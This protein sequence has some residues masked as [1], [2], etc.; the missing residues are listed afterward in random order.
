MALCSIY[1]PNTTA[2]RRKRQNHPRPP[3]ESSSTQ[4]FPESSSQQ[5]EPE[6]YIDDDDLFEIER[7]INQDFLLDEAF[8]FDTDELDVEDDCKEEEEEDDDDD[9]EE[10]ED[11]EVGEGASSASG[12]ECH[13]ESSGS[14]SIGAKIRPRASV[15]A[16]TIN[17]KRGSKLLTNTE[18]VF[19]KPEDCPDASETTIV[20]IDP[21]EIK[22]AYATRISPVNNTTRIS[23]DIKRAF[24]YRPYTKFRLLVQ[25]RKAASGIGVFESRIPSMTI[26]GIRGYLEY[27]RKDRRRE[28]LLAHLATAFMVFTRIHQRK[29]PEEELQCVPANGT[30]VKI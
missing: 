1:W 11:A 10:E 20:G 7:D 14:P 25:A 16:D 12:M 30:K 27:L 19:A 29:V 22:T 5:T 21:G 17:C 28:Q 15:S 18:T 9:D 24:L 23:V 4:S 2:L 8:Q 26:Q 13:A 6:S 3:E